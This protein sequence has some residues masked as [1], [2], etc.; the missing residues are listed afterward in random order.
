MKPIGANIFNIQPMSTEDGPG[1]RTTV[2]MKGCNMRCAW[3]QN[4]EGLTTEVHL[5]HDSV[6]CIGCGLC[7]ENCPQRALVSTEGKGFT[8]GKSCLRCLSCAQ[9]CPAAAIRAIGERMDID[10]L[11]AKVT[12]D[13]P[14]YDSSEGGVTFSGGE[15]LLQHEFLLAVLPK[16]KEQGIHT[17]IDT[18]AGVPS[19]LFQPVAKEADLVLLDIKIM[20]EER[21][22]ASTGLS[23]KMVL[24]NAAWLAGSGVP[25]WVR[26]PIV[27]GFTDDEENIA[28]I[29]GFIASEMKSTERIDLL[30]YND[31]C[32]H[33][34]QRLDWRYELT[35]AGR[36]K[37]SEMLRLQAIMRETG[38]EIVTISNYLKG[39]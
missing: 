19:H 8:F 27:P 38:A 35:N 11:L 20:E 37:E 9:S 4:P 26:V 17:C 39:V 13:K 1:I 2:F 24:E 15:C 28:A 7:Q 12:R 5:T 16:L 31:L 18:A 22:R 21:H 25:F 30:G 34:Y 36:V 33:D 29:A 14:F 3:C 32:V 10:S 6:R 23:N